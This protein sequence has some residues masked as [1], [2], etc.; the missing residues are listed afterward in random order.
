MTLLSR[1]IGYVPTEERRGI[2]LDEADPWRVGGTRV[3]RAFLRALPA[4]MP[5][6]SVLYLE[7]VPEAHVAQYLAEVSI[8]AAAKV[9][10]GTIWPRPNVFHLSLTAEV[11]EALTAFLEVHPAG[12]FCTH[13]H[14]YSDGRML[15]QWHDAFGSDPMYISRVL[16]GDHVRDFAA[17]LGS[18]VNSGW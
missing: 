17:K 14:V 3:E 16:E 12:Y 10:M 2:R 11:I 18:T 1:L 6:D 8:P 4:L 7:G 13:C 5:A 9:A 15:L